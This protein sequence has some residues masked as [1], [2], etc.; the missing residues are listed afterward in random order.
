MSGTAGWR[1]RN[2]G[3]SLVELMV[4]MTIG[5][6]LLGG[7]ISV[8]YSSKVTYA[9]NER[10]A[11]LQE[12]GRA[13]VEL[14]LRDMRAGGFKGCNQTTPLTNALPSPTGLLWNFSAPVQGFESTGASSW[15]PAVDA[16]IV[17][18]R[19]GSDIIAVRTSRIDAPT[20][21][22]NASPATSTAD[23][24]VDK[25]TT[26][27]LPTPSTVMISDCSAAAVFRV[28]TFTDGGGTATL[29]HGVD[30]GIPF[31]AG[32]LVVPV[33]TIIY[34]IRDS[35]TVRNGVRSPSLWRK[36]GADAEQELIEGIE[37][38]QILY[39]VDADG[40]RLV[41]SYEKASAITNWSRVISVSISMLV[42][43]LEPNALTADTGTYPML[44][45]SFTAPGDRYERTL[46]T[47]TV[48]LRNN[49]Q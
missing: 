1:A 29:A 16:A 7:A 47:T 33:D 45:T 24:T 2:R 27:T 26:D 44:D 35:A 11:R 28:T 21:T 40:D 17:T 6:I 13:A 4:S 32:A 41:N 15:S 23:L 37:S 10:V 38:M 9:E 3:F 8:L 39:G 25:A 36:V 48:A 49:T 46:Y 5:L 43:S 31:P 34:F 30:L 14:M 42:R 20:F 18:P 12:S 19:G 22:T